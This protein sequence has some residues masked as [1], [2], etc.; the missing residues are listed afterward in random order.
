MKDNIVI[1]S[2]EPKLPDTARIAY[3]NIINNH[4]QEQNRLRENLFAQINSLYR[5][6]LADSLHNEDLVRI[7]NDN[8]TYKGITV[9]Y[10]NAVLDVKLNNVGFKGLQYTFL[11]EIENYTTECNV[12]PTAYNTSY[13]GVQEIYAFGWIKAT[14]KYFAD[15]GL[16]DVK[17]DNKWDIN[18]FQFYIGDLGN[19]IPK[20]Q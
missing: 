4:A 12:L 2:S 16:F 15:K 5:T 3:Q 20:A 10:T 11:Y 1:S 6:K 13:G 9:N 7:N 17:L 8:Y 19:V 18:M 14:A